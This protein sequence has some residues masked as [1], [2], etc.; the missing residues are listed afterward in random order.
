MAE[1]LRRAIGNRFNVELGRW[2][3]QPVGPHPVPMY[4]AAFSAADVPFSLM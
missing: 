1:R 3:E 2:R 4:Q